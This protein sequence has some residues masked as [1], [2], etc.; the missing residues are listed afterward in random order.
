MARLYP[1]IDIAQAYRREDTSNLSFFK[2]LLSACDNV[3]HI[4]LKSKGCANWMSDFVNFMPR[5]V[6]IISFGDSRL[7]IPC[8][9]RDEITLAIHWT[10]LGAPEKDN[11]E[12]LQNIIS[13]LGNLR[14]IRVFWFPIHKTL[15]F[16]QLLKKSVKEIH[17]MRPV[18]DELSSVPDIEYCSSLT[19]LSLCGM[20]PVAQ[21]CL[22]KALIEGHLCNLTNL[23]VMDTDLCDNQVIIAVS[24]CHQLTSLNLSYSTLSVSGCQVIASFSNR[25]TSL[26]IT[27]DLVTPCLQG[28]W[29]NLTNVSILGA[30]RDFYDYEFH[31]IQ[32]TLRYELQNAD[33][34]IT[35]KSDEKVSE[36]IHGINPAAMPLISRI[37]LTGCIVSKPDLRNFT[38]KIVKWKILKLDI[39]HSLDLTGNL[40]I[41]LDQTLPYL[42]SLILCDCGL[43]A[44]DLRSLAKASLEGRLPE[45]E[46][47]D[48]SENSNLDLRGLFEN[49]C[50]WSQLKGL[51]ISLVDEIS[52]YKWLTRSVE[53]G[54]LRSLEQLRLWTHNDSMSYSDTTWRHLEKLEIFI[55]RYHKNVKTVISQI[56][57]MYGKDRLPAL[58]TVSVMIDTPEFAKEAYRLRQHN[59]NVHVGSIADQ[60][61]LSKVGLL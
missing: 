16:P 8:N 57:D 20:Y 25:L 19:H 36:I 7:A 59:I 52:D 22:A 15:I 6:S 34:R 42:D 38:E 30:S 11:F 17:V 45:L 26:V 60:M 4:I 12:I 41:L 33:S 35:R 10:G 49:G 5:S 43:N 18:T 58:R 23:C 9:E 47:I 39:S 2:E 21:V 28:T 40:D 44:R 31:Y 46:H 27:A 61:F 1:A 13:K 24:T 51:S 29:Q 48:I 14:V 50:T 55:L 32:F 56:A 37:L 54:C 3:R 53:L